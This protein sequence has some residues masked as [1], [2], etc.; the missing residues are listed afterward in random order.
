[1]HRSVWVRYLDRVAGRNLTG[2]VHRWLDSPTTP[3]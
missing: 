1:V 2:F 3:A